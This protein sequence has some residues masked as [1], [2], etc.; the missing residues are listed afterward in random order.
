MTHAYIY[1]A[2]RTPRGRAKET[3][4]LHALSP[5]ALLKTLYDALAERNPLDKNQVDDVILGCVTQAGD[6]AANIAKNLP[7]IC[8]LAQPCSRYYRKPVL[9]LGLGC[10]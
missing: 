10:H 9:F 4:G 1:D 3:G 6:Q 2:I 7:V 8:R 5:L